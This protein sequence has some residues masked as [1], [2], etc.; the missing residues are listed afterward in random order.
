MLELNSSAGEIGIGID[1]VDQN[2]NIGIKGERTI[3][4]GTGAFADTINIGNVTG[5]TAVNVNS[6]TG[7]IAMASAG[8]GDIT[9]T[10]SDTLLLDS[11]GVLELNS[12]AGEIG[13][14]NDAVAQAINIGTGGASRTI[15]V[16]NVTGATAVNVNSGTGGIALASTGRWRHYT[17]L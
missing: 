3:S 17:Y 9:L 13:I 1:D 2:I 4:T 15:T 6:G 12:S 16:G 10:S 14:G 7:G 5:A 8:T 11:A